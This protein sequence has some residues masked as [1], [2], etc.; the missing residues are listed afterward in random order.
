VLEY[1]VWCC[2]A[3]GAP[4][5]AQGDDYYFAFAT[6][7]EALE[8]SSRSPGAEEPC[9]LVRQLEWVDEPEPGIFVRRKGE[10]MTEWDPAWLS[11]GPRPPNAIEAFMALHT[12]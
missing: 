9:V 7:E 10:R 11:R 1:R 4:D 6:Y 12:H 3:R 5:E 8:F 2:P